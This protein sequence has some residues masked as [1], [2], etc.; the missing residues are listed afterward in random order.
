[1]KPHELFW[2]AVL[3]VVIWFGTLAGAYTAGKETST[4]AVAPVEVY[5]VAAPPAVIVN[6]CP[7]PAEAEALPAGDCRVCGPE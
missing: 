5:P 1:M 4:V 7:Q 2:A 3:M 6:G